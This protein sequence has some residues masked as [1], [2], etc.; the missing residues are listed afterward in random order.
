MLITSPNLILPDPKCDLDYV[1]NE[2][3]EKKVKIV[4]SISAGFGGVNAAILSKNM[5]R[6]P[7][8]FDPK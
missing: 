2:S 1:P 4:L 6:F 7:F 3:K 5:K 8:P